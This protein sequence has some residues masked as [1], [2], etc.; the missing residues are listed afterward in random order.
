MID[1]L[2]VNS[3]TQVL[4]SE[5]WFFLIAENTHM[6]IKTSVIVR[7]HGN[8]PYLR[9]ALH[10]ILRQTVIDQISILIVTDRPSI[11]S[12]DLIYE[13]VG[14]K[15]VRIIESTVPGGPNALNVGLN[16]VNSE[17]TAILD[18][19]DIMESS[20]I[21]KQVD[22]LNANQDI[23][24]V[25]SGIKIINASGDV[26]GSKKYESDPR[27]IWNNRYSNV[28]LANPAVLFRT[29]FVKEIGGYR[30]FYPYG[31]D[32]DLWFRIMEKG[33]I[34]NLPD[35]LTY[36]RE[37]DNQLTRIHRKK[38]ILHGLAVH[39]SA[40]NRAR[41]KPDLSEIYFSVEEWGKSPLVKFKVQ[42]RFVERNAI[43]SLLH[44]VKSKNWLK[45]IMYSCLCLVLNPKSVI[46]HALR[47]FRRSSR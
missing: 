14:S 40:R 17:F 45:A 10:S 41:G 1:C 42:K 29:K 31:D 34:S 27:I 21:E 25:G 26:V 35:Y 28:P 13:F 18:A 16:E 23:V 2:Q 9:Q 39:K 19:D 7:V 36:Y 11:L 24:V 4:E 44:N 12:M 43:E 37:H 33:R 30:S 8:T 20:R 6:T 3:Y 22:F 38:I 15:N 32:P 47:F 46:A 5:V